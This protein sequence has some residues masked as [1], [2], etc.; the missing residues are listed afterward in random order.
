MAPD[1]FAYAPLLARHRIAAIA[2]S[3]AAVPQTARAFALA[4][5]PWASP[6][7]VQLALASALFQ[8]AVPVLFRAVRLLAPSAA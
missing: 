8:A 5:G 1:R 2:G 6:A 3:V 7:R 4:E